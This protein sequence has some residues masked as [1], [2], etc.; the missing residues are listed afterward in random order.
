MRKI[1]SACADAGHVRPAEEDGDRPGDQGAAWPSSV[2]MEDR[3]SGDVAH[4]GI[5]W[6]IWSGAGRAVSSA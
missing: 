4:R 5:S 1:A 3:L 2:R 6:T